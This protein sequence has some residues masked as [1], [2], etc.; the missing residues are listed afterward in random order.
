MTYER[1]IMKACLLELERHSYLIPNLSWFKIR[2]LQ[3]NE[4]DIVSFYERLAQ[5]NQLISEKVYIFVLYLIV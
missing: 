3:Q 5:E 1:S 4:Y 2:A